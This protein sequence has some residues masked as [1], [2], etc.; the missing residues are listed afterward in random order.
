MPPTRKGYQNTS[1][2]SRQTDDGIF[3]V[4]GR[5][6]CQRVENG[7]RCNREFAANSHSISSHNSDFHTP[8][9]YQQLMARGD[10]KCAYD[11]CNHRS[12][13][14]Q[15]ILAHIR[16]SHKF[17]GSSDP[18]KLYYGIP[19]RTR[20]KKSSQKNV[21]SIKEDDLE[22]TLKNPCENTRE[23]PEELCDEKSEQESEDDHDDDDDY[24]DLIDPRLRKWDEDNG[25]GNGGAGNSGQL[26][27][28]NV[29]AA[30]G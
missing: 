30:S 19:I 11:R 29:I 20:R 28:S 16:S 3:Y 18:L 17:K 8:G 1:G 14:F 7:V 26:L 4:N 2:V 24:L 23:E 27:S 15:A 9:R 10:Y 12:E 13:N 21:P 25:S 5:Y 6:L 22:G